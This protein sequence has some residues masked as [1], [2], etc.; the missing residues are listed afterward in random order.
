V[1]A[2]VALHARRPA[3]RILETPGRTV[4]AY[5]ARGCLR[6]LPSG[7]KRARTSI[8]LWLKP[9]NGTWVAACGLLIF[10]IDGRV[11]DQETCRLNVLVT[12]KAGEV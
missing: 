5:T 9:A 11:V 6:E 1:S 10:A 12:E 4:G 8:L 7:A 3:C 2:L